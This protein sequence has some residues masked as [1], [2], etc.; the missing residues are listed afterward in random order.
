ML[1]SPRSED[2]LPD[3]PKRRGLK[4][5]QGRIGR[6]KSKMLPSGIVV[7]DGRKVDAVSEGMPIE[8]G[9]KVRVLYAR[10]NSV[11]VRSVPE[12]TP[13]RPEGDPLSRPVDTVVPDPFEEPPA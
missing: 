6:A 5:L 11:V 4:E 8:A 12:D 1:G 13:E 10:G 7:V 9:Q 2:V 3:D